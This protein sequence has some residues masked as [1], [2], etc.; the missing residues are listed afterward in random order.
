MTDDID[1]VRYRAPALEKGLD[2]LELLAGS[3]EPM[4]MAQLSKALD[5]SKGEIFRMLQV[6]E[7]RGYIARHPGQDG[8]FLTNQL[9]R[10]GIERSPTRGLLEVGLPMMH[11]LSSKIGQACHLAVASGDQ[12]VVIA[13]VESPAALGFSVRLGHRAPILRSNSGL[14]LLAGRLSENAQSW[15]EGSTNTSLEVPA[16][17]EPLL[18]D[19]R[20]AK[21]H[22]SASHAVRGVT[23]ISAPIERSGVTLAALTVP[24]VELDEAKCPI[25]EATDVVLE[26]ARKISEAVRVGRRET[27]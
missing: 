14:V 4:Q 8:Y 19:I 27:G 21:V 16:D 13:K 5:R 26:T 2:I 10:L 23:D 20:L 7:N 3:D 1:A 6:L 17:L 25:G 18:T 12:I 22:T 9:F 15:I 11:D 24:Y